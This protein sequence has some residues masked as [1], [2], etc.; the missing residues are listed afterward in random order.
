MHPC[1]KLEYSVGK[2]QNEMSL[3]LRYIMRKFSQMH[4]DYQAL[5]KDVHGGMYEGGRTPLLTSEEK[6]LLRQVDER[7]ME[8]QKAREILEKIHPALPYLSRRQYFEHM[9]AFAAHYS[10]QL[11]ASTNIMVS[12]GQYKK[13]WQLLH[14]WVTP[15]YTEYLLNN[16][17]FLC[18][19]PAAWLTTVP[20]GTSHAETL[21][22]RVN[23]AMRNLPECHL[24]FVD[25]AM[26]ALSTTKLLKHMHQ[27]RTPTIRSGRP[28][29][30]PV[31]VTITEQEWRQHVTT[32]TLL[33]L[34]N[35]RQ[36]TK[37]QLKGKPALRTK[38]KRKATALQRTV[39][40]QRHHWNIWNRPTARMYTHR[41]KRKQQNTR[42][43]EA[44][45]EEV[46]RQA[47]GGSSSSIALPVE[48]QK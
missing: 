44:Q 45:E 20:S 14:Q 10:E 7:S 23:R 21:C 6:E 37:R 28:Q 8:K 24:A 9:A 42:R 33:P 40:I 46:H 47:S 41:D 26:Q 22:F 38:Q 48:S 2:Q 29:Q 13:A 34:F 27:T 39:G 16:T 36:S 12:P 19:V 18:R 1:Y 25:I 3:T 35:M 11:N 15:V 5:M 43:Q 30:E 4:D 31:T 32:S 17:R